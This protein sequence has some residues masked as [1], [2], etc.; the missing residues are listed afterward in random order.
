MANHR[1]KCD[2]ILANCPDH[3]RTISHVQLVSLGFAYRC[4]QYCKQ[5]LRQLSVL[6]WQHFCCYHGKVLLDDSFDAQVS[7]W[8][9]LDVLF[10]LSILPHVSF[11]FAMLQELCEVKAISLYINCRLILRKINFGQI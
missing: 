9:D 8:R 5:S 7:T 11:Y 6:L 4:E 3:H 2:R 10:R 1:D